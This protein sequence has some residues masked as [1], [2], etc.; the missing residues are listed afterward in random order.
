MEAAALGGSVLPGAF[1]LLLLVLLLLAAARRRPA[2]P[3]GEYCGHGEGSRAGP[4]RPDPTR[5]SAPHRPQGERCRRPRPAGGAQ[6][7][8][9]AGA[10]PAG[11]AAAAQLRPPA[12]GRRP[13]GTVCAPLPRR[14]PPSSC[15]W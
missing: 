14:A 3:D 10:G 4:A 11:Q 15:P 2:P 7:G 12:A 13:Q 8:E 9:G 1:A 5:P 6:E